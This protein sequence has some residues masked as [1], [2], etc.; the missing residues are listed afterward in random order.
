M[1]SPNGAIFKEGSGLM[2]KDRVYILFEDTVVECTVNNIDGDPDFVR[3]YLE[4]G[5]EVEVDL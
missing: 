4:G 1:G 5:E 2:M 3:F